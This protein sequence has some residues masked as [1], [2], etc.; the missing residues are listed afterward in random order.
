MRGYSKIE[1]KNSKHSS[2]S[3]RP[4]SSKKSFMRSIAVQYQSYSGEVSFEWSCVGFGSQTQKSNQ[5]NMSIF[6]NY[7]E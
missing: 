2:T 4:G 3:R 6:I 7:A 5:R 1:H